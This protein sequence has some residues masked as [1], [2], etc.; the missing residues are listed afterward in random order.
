MI[1]D[2]HS[3][4][5]PPAWESSGVLPHDMFEVDAVFERQE[6]AGID[7]TV[8]SDPH[9]WYGDRDLG[10]IDCTRGYNDFAA[11]LNRAHGRRLRALATCTPW[12]GA[13][14]VE[15]LERAVK[16][17]GLPGVALATSDR[18]RYLDEVPDSFWEAV[19]ALEVPVFVHPGGTVLGQEHMG[20]YRL[21]EVCGRPLDMTL[22][23]SRFILTGAFERHPGVRLLCAHAGGAICTVAGRLDFGHELRDY[24]PLGPWGEVRL[25]EPPSAFVRRLFLDTVTF[26]PEPLRLALATV[27]E[28]QICF[29]TDGPPVPF[30]AS[31]GVANVRALDA[32][33]EVTAAIL[34]GNA[35]ALFGLTGGR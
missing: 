9:I 20:S 12:R 13:E 30:A 6:E 1:V 5:F 4:L 7:L 24:A 3:H 28:A 25:R 29:G 35:Q 33:P 17:L 32:G 26:G 15:E 31:R 27:G 8:I 11:E 14:H 18:G 16:E 19:T 21:G 34:G 22:S 23:L 10:A 2:A